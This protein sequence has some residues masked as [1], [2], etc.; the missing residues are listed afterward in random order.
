MNVGSDLFDALRGAGDAGVPPAASDGH[1]HGRSGSLREITA[2]SAVCFAVAA[3]IGVAL[4]VM[5]GSSAL[6]IVAAAGLLIGAAYAIPPIKLAHRGLDE[7]ATAVVFGPV[8]LVGT[9]LIQ[10]RGALYLEPLLLSVPVGLLAAVIV[11][12]NGIRRRAADAK[13]GRSTLPVRLPKRAVVA[14]FGLAAGASFVALVAGV[15]T[16]LLPIPALIALVTIPLAL[17]IRAGLVRSDDE[18]HVLLDASTESTLLHTNVSLFLLLTYLLVV[19]DV[20]FLK[21]K[22]Y[23]W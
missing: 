2:P 21:L 7:L 13:L 15:G 18:P 17:R 4:L 14:G 3:V 19:A 1:P 23:F 9:Y 10:S 6:A 5:R 12:V 22:P 20:V 8:L 16:G 11:L